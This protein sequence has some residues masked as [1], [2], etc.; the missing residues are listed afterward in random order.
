MPHWKSQNPTAE[1]LETLRGI[2]ALVLDV[3][4][5]LTD[6]GII[7]GSGET[8]IKRFDCRDGL[9]LRLWLKSGGQLAIITGRESEAVRLRARD[10]GVEYLYQ[11]CGD[12][13]QVF[14]RFLSE[15]GLPAGQVAAVG[16]DLIDIPMLLQ[17][18]LPVAVGDAARETQEAAQL[19]TVRPGGHGALRELTEYLLKAQGKWDKLVEEY[20]A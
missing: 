16:D 11:K 15:S 6:G 20:Y 10:L 9:G 1:Q 8:E 4:G 7:Y 18:G 5:V 14:K 12:K 13:K 17:A 19:I 2:K 3:D